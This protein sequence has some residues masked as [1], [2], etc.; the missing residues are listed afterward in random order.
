MRVFV[1]SKAF[2]LLNFFQNF[3]KWSEFV[4]YFGNFDWEKSEKPKKKV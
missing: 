2:Q 1:A 3:D 4:V